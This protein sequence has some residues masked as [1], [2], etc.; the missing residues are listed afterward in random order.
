M[1]TLIP[2]LPTS[3]LVA[4]GW[5]RKIVSAYDIGAG[6]TLQG[7]DPETQVLSWGTTGFVTALVVGGS[8]NGTVPMREPVL[9]I[10][11]YAVNEKSKSRPPWGRANAM[12][13]LIV[14][15]AYSF[16]FNDTQGPVDLG[17]SGLVRVTDGSV[18]TE[19]ERR[20]SDAANYAR[21]G[22]ELSI[23][24]LVLTPSLPL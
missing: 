9:S 20:P 5:I 2:T 16:K 4:L 17:A 14:R 7:P 21:Y 11:C 10:D 3:E 15:S 13:E 23:S 19:P 22:F 8:V 18:Q 6:T 24:W 1:A 12:A